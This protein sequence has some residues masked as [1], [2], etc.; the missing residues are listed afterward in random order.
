MTTEMFEQLRKEFQ[1]EFEKINDYSRMTPFPDDEIMNVFSG[2]SFPVSKNE[3]IKMTVATSEKTNPHYHSFLELAY[4]AEGSA[5]HFCDGRIEKITKGDYFIIDYNVSHG[6][7]SFPGEGELMIV[8]CLFLPPFIDK[9]LG[10]YLPFN[11][12]LSNYLIR[13]G[14]KSPVSRIGDF[15]FHDDDGHIRAILDKMLEEYYC[16]KS[17]YLEILRCNLIEMIIHTM[18]KADTSDRETC[19]D[20]ISQIKKYVDENY[21][22][23]ITLTSISHDLNFSLPY[24]CKKFK[25]ETGLLFSEYLQKVRV[26][27]GCR[28]LANT[29]K[30]IIDIAQLVGYDDIKFFGLVF[31]KHMNMSP[32]AYRKLMVHGG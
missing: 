13:F 1:Q 24:L 31:K 15:I 3:K 4:V 32:G 27:Q 25:S 23:Q 12:V 21:M 20:S 26:E 9:T 19:G 11:N 10:D 28:L 18:R 29:D 17:G 22:R 2:N 5:L 30:K 14:D 16:K 6:Y 8:N 7:L